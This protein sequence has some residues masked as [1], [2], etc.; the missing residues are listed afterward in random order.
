L[1]KRQLSRQTPLGGL[2]AGNQSGQGRVFLVQ[3]ELSNDGLHVARQRVVQIAVLGGE[4]AEEPDQR[5]ILVVQAELAED[6]LV[7]RLNHG[8][9]RALQRRDELVVTRR[10]EHPKE[11]TV[12][13]DELLEDL[14]KG[15]LR[16]VH[17]LPH[18]S[19]KFPIGLGKPMN[20]FRERALVWIEVVFQRTGDAL[21]ELAAPHIE[22]RAEFLHHAIAFAP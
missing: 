2:D 11:P 22:P 16:F 14:R 13:A 5:T 7:L 8:V 6:R 17:L 15:R 1:S 4:F 19:R 3:T 20:A 21:F 18:D 12:L 10:I 9:E